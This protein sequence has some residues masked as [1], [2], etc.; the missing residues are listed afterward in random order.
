MG[1]L[2]LDCLERMFSQPA[3]PETDREYRRALCR[4]VLLRNDETP[5][6]F[7]QRHWCEPCGNRS[8]NSKRPLSPG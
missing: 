5:W 3:N 6:S 8:V 4:K 2:N 1:E 7:D